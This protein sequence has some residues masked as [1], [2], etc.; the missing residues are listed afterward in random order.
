MFFAQNRKGQTTIPDG[1]IVVL[2]DVEKEIFKEQTLKKI[3]SFQ[4]HL[5]VIAS[6]ESS[7]NDKLIYKE[8][9][10][11]NF[12]NNGKTVVMEVSS[13]SKV[14]GKERRNRLPLIKYLNNLCNLSYAKID[15]KTAKSCY[16][17]NWIKAGYDNNGNPFY[18][19]TA[20]YYQEF[21]GYSPEG[22]PLYH[23]ITRKT[24]E[25]EIRFSTDLDYS[26]WIVYLGD[27]SVADTTV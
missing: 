17:S 14:T 2:N 12:V 13:K 18:K 20:T 16:V 9:A 5:L 19:A 8:I 7:K 3:K 15:L 26:R 23:D 4:G 10:L 6:K 1:N 22:K 27:I 11:S 24:I 21:T 25:V